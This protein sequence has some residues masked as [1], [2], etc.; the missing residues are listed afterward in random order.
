MP[1]KADLLSRRATHFVLWRPN[2]IS[3]VPALVI[4]KFQPGNPPT[5][6]GRRRIAM[7]QAVGLTGLWEIAASECG[8][9]AG[10]VA[11]YWFEVENTDPHRSASGNVLC[12]DPAAHMVDWRLCAEGGTQPA[13]V[14]QFDGTNLV[15]CDPAGEKP[16][17]SS[18][19]PSNTLPANNRLVIYELPTAWTVA[20][21]QG[22]KERGVG[23]FRRPCAIRR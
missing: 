22:Q 16:D 20:Q 15:V 10:D 2:D 21:E 17:F 14:I 6:A 9:V 11:H 8:L 4:G 1:I 13:A 23:T 7:T 19:V 12:T 3:S 5:L 18:D